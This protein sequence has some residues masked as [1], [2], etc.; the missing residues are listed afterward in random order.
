MRRHSAPA[1]W[2]ASPTPYRAGRAALD[3]YAGLPGSRG[4]GHRIEHI[5]YADPRDIERFAALGV[6]ASMQPLH[7]V[8]DDDPSDVWR[9]RMGPARSRD[10]WP[11]ASLARA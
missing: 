10:L 4:A 5:E 8:P 7:H 11:W 9:A 2:C 3:A 6:I 1:T